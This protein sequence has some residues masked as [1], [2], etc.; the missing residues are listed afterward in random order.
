VRQVAVGELADHR[1]RLPRLERE[2]QEVASQVV[3]SEQLLARPG[4]SDKA[5]PEVV[6]RERDKLADL[7]Q[8]LQLLDERLATLRAMSDES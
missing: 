1:E 3:R 5:P 7:R 6:Q 4:F 8:R 2:R